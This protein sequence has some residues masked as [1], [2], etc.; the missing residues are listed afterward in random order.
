MSLAIRFPFEDPLE[1]QILNLCGLCFEFVTLRQLARAFGGD[2]GLITRT[3][4]RLADRGQIGCVTVTESPPQP[5]HHPLATFRGGWRH[6]RGSPIRGCRTFQDIANVLARRKRVEAHQIVVLY[7]NEVTARQV[8]APKADLSRLTRQLHHDLQVP[9][10][11]IAKRL[12]WGR[13]VDREGP[14]SF[15]TDL[16]PTSGPMPGTDL[17]R[18]LYVWTAVRRRWRCERWLKANGLSLAGCYPD[19]ACVVEVD[20]RETIWSADDY[21][22]SY[23]AARTGEL[24][25]AAA[26]VGK[27]QSEFTFGFW[28]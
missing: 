16:E 20:G 12:R 26:T 21:A 3:V 5:L 9:E 25:R 10:I 28:G 1:E 24:W 15:P 6:G 13:M 8:D 17:D 18:Q 22:G 27:A 11:F 2:R 23:D 19:A 4:M 14:V 7:A